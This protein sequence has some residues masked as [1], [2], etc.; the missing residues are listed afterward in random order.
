MDPYMKERF[1]QFVK[2]LNDAHCENAVV[3]CGSWAEYLYQES[4]L[5]Q[6]FQPMLKTKD[7]DIYI[8]DLHVPHAKADLPSLAKEINFKVASD[9]VTGQT[10]FVDQGVD[11]EI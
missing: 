10:K 3:I 9:Y 1:Y 6:H 8:P 7:V 4:G 5:L 11:F 2:C